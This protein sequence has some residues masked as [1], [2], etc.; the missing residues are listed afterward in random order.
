MINLVNDNPSRLA[1]SCH[2]A[3]E[4]ESIRKR[5]FES[6]GTDHP[7]IQRTTRYPTAMQAGM[8][9][10]IRKG[11]PSTSATPPQS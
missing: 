8:K 9:T 7:M 3:F 2:T 1:R 10:Q 5:M 6:P 11:M 4:A